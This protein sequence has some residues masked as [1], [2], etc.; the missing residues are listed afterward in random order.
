MTR[1]RYWLSQRL[2]WLAFWVAPSLSSVIDID[3]E[4]ALW[5]RGY[6]PKEFTA[7]DIDEEYDFAY[8]LGYQHGFDYGHDTGWEEGFEEGQSLN[9]PFHN[10]VPS[11]LVPT[12][13]DLREEALASAGIYDDEFAHW[14]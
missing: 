13:E 9:S 1:I 12:N 7:S 8:D 11:T 3:E 5:S 4:Q 14:A 10:D 6:E 2:W